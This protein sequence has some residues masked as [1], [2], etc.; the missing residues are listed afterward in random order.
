MVP[1]VRRTLSIA[2]LCLAWLCA[3]G[4]LWNVVQLVGW[5]KMFHCKTAPVRRRPAA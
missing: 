1:A 4:A 5:A 2:C 3:N